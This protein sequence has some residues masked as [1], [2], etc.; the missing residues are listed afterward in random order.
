MSTVSQIGE[1]ALVERIRRKL[2]GGADVILGPGDDC[3]AVESPASSHL[4]TLLKTDCIVEGIHFEPHAEPDRIGWKAMARAISDIGACGGLPRHAL[5]T[6]VCDPDR[7][8]EG[9]DALYDGMLRAADAFE[10]RIVGGETS[11][12]SQGMVL[13]IAVTGTVER[14]RLV[15]RTGAESGDAIYVT[16]QLGGS[17]RGWHFD[18]IPRVREARWLTE[19][20][21]LHAMMDLSDGLGADLPRLADASAVGFA[22]DLGALPLA[23]G[24]DQRAAISDGEDYELLFT[25][26]GSDAAAL[27]SAWRRHFPDL[28]LTRIGTICPDSEDRTALSD[29]F[30]HFSD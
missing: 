12:I 17:I 5:V 4:L 11:R 16:G 3:A 27:E 10:V 2:T 1:N 9:I 25:L 18:F 6:L 29:G 24:C 21:P 7:P 8:V 19:K 30:S 13:N 26:P 15:T 14:D 22:I 23:P 28:S 20:F